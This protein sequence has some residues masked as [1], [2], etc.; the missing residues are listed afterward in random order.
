[1]IYIHLVA[2]GKKELLNGYWAWDRGNN[3][4]SAVSV[5]KPCSVNMDP[6][7]MALVHSPTEEVPSPDNVA[8]RDALATIPPNVNAP[9]VGANM[10]MLRVNQ[11]GVADT[12]LARIQFAQ[13]INAI[14]VNTGTPVSVIESLA[15]TAHRTRIE[16]VEAI[17]NSH[18]SNE[19]RSLEVTNARQASNFESQYLAEV[20]ELRNRA[21]RS[22][23][24]T[25]RNMIG[26][27]YEAVTARER[28]INQLRSELSI[29]QT[30]LRDASNA[31]DIMRVLREE[32][33]MEKA[34]TM[35]Y[36]TA[37]QQAV[38]EVRADC[39]KR[40]EYYQNKV[41]AEWQMKLQTEQQNYQNTL[42]IQRNKISAQAQE[43]EEQRSEIAMS[44]ER[45]KKMYDDVKAMRLEMQE[46][47][48]L[49]EEI[50]ESKMEMRRL[51][52]ELDGMP[53]ETPTDRRYSTQGPM[54]PDESF[55]KSGAFP[56]E[57][58]RPE[59][60]TPKK[61]GKE[62]DVPGFMKSNQREPEGNREKGNSYQ[63]AWAN[64]LGPNERSE[65]ARQ[66]PSREF[67]PR[68]GGNANPGQPS[69]SNRPN[70]DANTSNEDL[71]RAALLQVLG[72]NNKPGA[73]KVKEADSLKFPEFPRPENY[74]KWKT[75]VR[76][77][78]RASSDKPD[79]AWVWLMEVYQD[80]EDS[81]RLLQ[82]LSEPGQFVTLD[83]KILAQL[84][85]VAKGDLGTQILNFKEVEAAN[86]RVVRG[87]QVLFMFEQYFRTNE[88]AGA[89]YGTE[90]LLKIH[91]IT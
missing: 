84:S 27:Q 82:E 44:S 30:M 59:R 52:A 34:Q 67:G 14:S 19:V 68:G 87:R 63:D 18:Y 53:R 62:Y 3:R 77:E 39:V 31:E 12:E 50:L 28:T 81:R 1:M 54:P 38:A 91:L 80:R 4:L 35:S 61:A 83:T 5:L 6:D 17:M 90:D 15:E 36:E 75:A 43:L 26:E 48:T 64:Y 69:S 13:Q 49:K 7:A 56:S 40:E 58:P 41:N 46:N 60:E 71:L 79:E 86:G 22:E 10:T 72:S 9:G 11:A 89:L 55:P 76:E 47:Q 20:N 32:L 73:P 51:R 16:E 24:E 57:M 37:G 8:L 42:A 66:S 2:Q 33:R 45:Y 29:A 65:G 88:E 78:I 25:Q 70:I 21:S 85:R 23:V 74:R